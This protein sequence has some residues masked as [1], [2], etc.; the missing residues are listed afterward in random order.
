M[1]PGKLAALAGLGAL[2]HLDLEVVGVDE[3]LARHAEARRRDLLDRAAPRVAVRIA[4]CSAPDP[5][6]LRRCSTCRRGGSSRWRCVSCASWLIEPYDIAPVA[7]RLRIASTGST[8]SSGIGGRSALKSSRPRSVPSARLWSF[9]IVGELAVD[10][11]LPA[12]RRVLQL[13]HRLGVEEVQLAVAPP[14]V[15]AARRRARRRAGRPR[16]ERA[17]VPLLDLLRDDVDAD[18]A[19]ARRRPREVAVD[20]RLLEADRLEDLRAAVALQ[21]RDA[22]L[23]HHLEDALVERLDVVA[24]SPSRAS[25]PRRRA[26][27]IMSSSVSKA[28]YGFTAPAP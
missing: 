11:V 9:T 17:L 24:A 10:R 1:W 3:V 4:A 7:N 27:A 21:R 12:A 13:L 23:G 20:E 22:H 19:D 5:R 15:L 16:R 25:R 28:R 6:R 18:A 14:L 8:S 26:G 2:R